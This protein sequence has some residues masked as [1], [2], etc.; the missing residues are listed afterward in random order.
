M[1]AA[2]L[3][4]SNTIGAL[5]LL[6]AYSL[7][8]ASDPSVV[9]EIASNP[10]N[11]SALGLKPN[12]SLIMML[13]PFV[14]GLLAFGLLIKPLNNRSLKMTLTGAGSFRWNRFFISGMVW[15]IL[16]AT[17]FF[18]YLKMDPSNFTLNNT[19]GTLVFLVLI[20]VCLI[21]FQAAF[22]EVLFRGY[23]M[24]GFAV[25]AKNR[26]IPLL[27]TSLLFGLMHSFN[28]EVDEFGFFTMMPQYFL[29]GLIFGILTVL[30]D[31]I[32]AA[33]G[34]HTANNAFLCIFVTNSSSALQT[35]AVYEQHNIQPWIEFAGL[36]ITGIIFILILKML[37]KWKDYSI[38]AGKVEKKVSTGQE[39]Y[40]D[41]LSSVR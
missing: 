36:F 20:C 19:S 15:L 11:I 34:A 25:L 16:S 9:T 30:D 12:V 14:A 23:L 8:A 7:K 35:Q 27:M 6:V 37:F 38:L 33:I 18:V 31:G 40:T 10:N 17:Y 5:P 39:P 24:Q 21:P 32:E 29:F 28:P 1:F 22:E 13:F 41:V 2:V 26:W 4:V 3:I